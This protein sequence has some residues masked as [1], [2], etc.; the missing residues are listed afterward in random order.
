MFPIAQDCIIV[1][2]Q[3]PLIN[4]TLVFLNSMMSS[5]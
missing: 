5:F 2:L 3:I 4:M 1:F